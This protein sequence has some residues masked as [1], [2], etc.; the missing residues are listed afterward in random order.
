MIEHR[1][2]NQEKYYKKATFKMCD[3]AFLGLISSFTES[4]PQLIVNALTQI[5]SDHS[6]IP[7]TVPL[8]AGKI[9]SSL[10]E[11]KTS[12]FIFS[13]PLTCDKFHTV[14]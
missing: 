2:D 13:C 6:S 9:C 10:T 5:Q 8:Y 7:S 11:L 4:A 3:L 1:S 12:P 14:H